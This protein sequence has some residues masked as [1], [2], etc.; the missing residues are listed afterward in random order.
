MPVV[1]TRL[2]VGAVVMAAAWMTA[3]A[4]MRMTHGTMPTNIPIGK[5]RENLKNLR[6]QKFSFSKIS[7]KIS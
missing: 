5:N 4:R 3:M 6:L 2:A 1:R 7:K